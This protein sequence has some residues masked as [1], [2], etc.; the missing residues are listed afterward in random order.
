MTQ[1]DDILAALSAA[2]DGQ[3]D[4]SITPRIKQLVGLPPDVIAPRSKEILD[5]CAFA[6]LASDFA[7]VAMDNVWRMALEASQQ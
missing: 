6:S 5:E 3:I 7:M 4:Q 2:P 1:L